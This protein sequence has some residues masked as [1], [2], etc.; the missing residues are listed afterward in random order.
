MI[1]RD[2]FEVLLRFSKQYPVVTV[3][4]PRQSG[5]TTIVKHLFKDKPYFNLEQISHFE[6]ASNDPEGFIAQM[7]DGGIIDEIQ[8]VPKLLNQIQAVIDEKKKN[9]FFI[10]TGSS[11]FELLSG[12]S[13]SLAGRTALFTLLPL[14][15]NEL[16]KAGMN[17]SNSLNIYQ[18]FMPRIIDENLNPSEALDFYFRTY[19]ERDVR[20]LM[21]IKNLSQFQMFVKMCAGRT[22][23]LL[24][25]SNLGSDVGVSHTTAKEWISILKASY[26]IF[27]L[28]P[29]SGNI[30]KRLMK[31]PKLYFYDVGLAAF[32]LGIENEK[33]ILTH[34]LY[35]SLFENMVVCEFLKHRFN[36]GKPAN[37]NFYRDSSG[38]EV[39]IICNLADSLIPVEIK[40]GMTVRDDF[41]KG[42]NYLDKTINNLTDEKIIVYGGDAI[43]RRSNAL[44]IPPTEIH[45]EMQNIWK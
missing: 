17:F 32:L 4:G 18:G 16:K 15:L 12:A 2:A 14:S 10:L 1:E 39:D 11:Q 40:A 29:F 36:C 44:I 22:G 28:E 38:N 8:R 30:G 43:Q 41:F 7:K 5:K 45:S 35:G 42:L 25:L 37:M 6:F 26:V 23:Q 34:P 20:N 19:V 27:T 24:N 9:G 13:Q 33:Q 21:Q 31:A 3:T